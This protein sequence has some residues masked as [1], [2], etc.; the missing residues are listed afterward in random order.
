MKL[1]IT[2]LDGIGFALA[3]MGLLLF[4]VGGM[5]TSRNGSARRELNRIICSSYESAKEESAKDTPVVLHFGW[6]PE[7]QRKYDEA[8]KGKA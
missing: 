5:L 3:S 2:I 7:Q 4:A 6:T 8:A 1:A